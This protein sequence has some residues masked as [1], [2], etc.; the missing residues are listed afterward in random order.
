MGRRLTIIVFLLLAGI[1][2]PLWIIPSS[3]SALAAGA[4][5]VQFGV[6]GAWGVIAIFLS[7]IS[8]PAFRA[9]F[10]GIAYQLGNMVS[11]A[12]AQIEATGGDHL[13]TTIIQDDQPMIVQDYAKVQ[14][15]F[16]GCIV[17]YTLVLVIVGPENHGS[18]FEKHKAAFEEGAAADDANFDDESVESERGSSPAGEKDDT[19]YREYVAKE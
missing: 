5:C 7:E 14:G 8:P 13:K 12:S 18:Q 15:I 16:I 2:I 9:S 11:A 17:A 1:F 19:D 6:Q 3:F 10:P 4:F